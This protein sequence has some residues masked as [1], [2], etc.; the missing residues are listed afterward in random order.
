MSVIVLISHQVNVKC[1]ELTL[2]IF[3]VNILK[4]KIEYTKYALI[5]K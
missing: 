5:R 3:C 4:F 1:N 2:L